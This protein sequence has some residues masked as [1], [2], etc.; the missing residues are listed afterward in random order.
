MTR[1]FIARSVVCAAWLGLSATMLAQSGSF[2]YDPA[3]E[4]TVTGKVV[5]VVSLPAPDG[6]G[7]HF[8]FRA[9]DGM[10]NVASFF[11]DDQLTL[12][13]VKAFIDGNR[14]FIVRSITKDGKTLTLRNAA[15]KPA[16]SPAVEGADGC[17]VAHPV[18]PRG[19]EM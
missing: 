15:G 12:V 13:G 10:L 4:T 9:P 6:V 8:D 17:G 16:W 11:A 18:L 3:A 1:N 14:S 7:V 19:T 2:A 5:A